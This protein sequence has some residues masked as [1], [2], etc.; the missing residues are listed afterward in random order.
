MRIMQAELSIKN[1]KTMSILRIIRNSFYGK[2]SETEE[3]SV[4][5]PDVHDNETLQ[6]F[7]QKHPDSAINSE[8]VTRDDFDFLQNLDEVSKEYFGIGDGAISK[9]EGNVTREAFTFEQ[10]LGVV[11]KEF[12]GEGPGA[13]EMISEPITDP[14][15]SFEENL[16]SIM[17]SFTGKGPEKL[18][19]VAGDVTDPKKDLHENF[20]AIMEN[21]GGSL[22]PRQLP[23]IPQKKKSVISKRIK[24]INY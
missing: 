9:S 16:V 14:E 5:N 7:P 2:P 22:N 12:M 24:G 4:F 13:L 19:L 21:F 8:C 18:D 11:C 1:K 3:N 20:Q 6:Q 23:Y 15:K 10:N 17:H